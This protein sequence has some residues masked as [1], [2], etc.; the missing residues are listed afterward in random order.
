MGVDGPKCRFPGFRQAADDPAPQFGANPSFLDASTQMR[1]V[2][3]E[4][5]CHHSGTELATFAGE[6]NRAPFR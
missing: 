6:G 1:G 5:L 2:F 3:G 4:F